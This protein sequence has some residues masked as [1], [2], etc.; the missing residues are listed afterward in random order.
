MIGKSSGVLKLL[1]VVPLAVT[2]CAGMRPAKPA[3]DPIA[4]EREARTA[5]AAKRFQNKWDRA[6][7]MAA[8]ARWNEGDADGCRELLDPL[9]ERNPNHAGARR[10]RARIDREVRTV[11]YEYPDGGERRPESPRDEKLP[12]EQPAPSDENGYPGR[13]DFADLCAAGRGSAARRALIR[14]AEAIAAAEGRGAAGQIEAAMAAEPDNRQIPIKAA[15][16]ALQHGHPD[17]AVPVAE[18]AV[19]AFGDSAALYRILGTAHYRLGDYKASQLAL[20]QALSLDN[21][22][23]LS[24]F[25][26]GSTLAKL[27][28][29]QAAD[30]HFRRAKL[31]DRPAIP[32]R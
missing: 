15:V 18:K 31:L 16:F 23:P 26:M 5:D 32:P 10:L 19:A 12:A 9:L 14:A 27:G 8:A 22:H 24:Y 28:E 30:R 2:G 11:G 21:S 29:S 6:R 20:R 4:E 1:L 25:L 3:G 17:V 13:D 7:Y